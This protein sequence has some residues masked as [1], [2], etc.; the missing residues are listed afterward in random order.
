MRALKAGVIGLGVGQRHVAAYRAM[1]GVEVAAVCDIDPVKL[2]AVAREHGVAKAHTDY[3]AVVEDP[4]IDLVSVCSFDDAHVDQAVAAF[5]NGKHVM[6]EKPIALYRE[7]A[8]RLLRAQQDS[9]R[10]ISTN[11]ILRESP[12]FKEIR[13]L[14]RRGAFGDVFYMEGDYLHQ[15]LW[16]ITEGWRGKMDFY[17][18][19]YGGGIHL[20]DLMRWIL[21][22]EV[23]EVC[24][25][26]NKILTRASRFPHP[27][28]LTHL[29]KFDDDVMAK[30]TTTFGPQRPQLHRL[31]L[32]GT[33]MTFENDRPV[34]HLYHS[35][36]PA[37]APDL[38]DTPYLS[39]DKGDLLPDFVAAIRE[40]REPA[41]GARD[42][43]RVMD[44]CFACWQSIVE[45]RTVDVAYML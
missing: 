8:E 3:R 10:R 35:D 17:C 12:R 40:D 45:R 31:N 36:D 27:D 22:R 19:T 39:M 23:T 14:V 30:T 38:V 13:D 33:A 6:V 5:E 7:D 42:V 43:F 4:D 1:D 28:T 26:G 11:V 44:I 24:G 29:L 41:V 9:G 2:D 20:I 21:G 37:A 15:I 18:V 16:K 32:F 34:G 25:M